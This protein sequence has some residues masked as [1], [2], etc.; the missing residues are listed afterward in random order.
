MTPAVKSSLQQA[1]KYIDHSRV[2]LTDDQSARDAKK[3]DSLATSLQGRLVATAKLKHDTD[4][5]KIQFLRKLYDLR[6]RAQRLADNKPI[7]YRSRYWLALAE[8]AIFDAQVEI[9]RGL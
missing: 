6:V 9:E 2:H 7:H 3:L 4:A 5:A 8:D 1:S